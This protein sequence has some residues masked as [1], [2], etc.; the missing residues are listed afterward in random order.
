MT[1]RDDA[2]GVCTVSRGFTVMSPDQVYGG[3]Y[4]QLCNEEPDL[5][6]PAIF[7]H[8]QRGGRER[9][10]NHHPARGMRGVWIGTCV[11]QRVLVW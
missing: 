11:C 8:R 4:I 5:D 3:I 2:Y 1:K 7:S 10:A 9:K 6:C